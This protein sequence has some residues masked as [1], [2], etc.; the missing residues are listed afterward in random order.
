MKQ[1]KTLSVIALH[2]IAL[3]DEEVE[4]NATAVIEHV[5]CPEILWL[6]P[7]AQ[8]R[9]VTI[10]AGSPALAWY[11]VLTYDRTRMDEDGIEEATSMICRAVRQARDRNRFDRVVLMGFSQGGALALNAGLR[12]QDEVDGIVA[13]GTALPFPDR[14][15]SPRTALPVFLGHGLLDRKIPYAFGRETERL[16]K[17]KGYETE[18]HSYLC[19]HTVTRRLLRDI[20]VWL[21][22]NFLETV[23]ARKSATFGAA[24]RMPHQA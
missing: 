9:D 2:G 3:S 21:R 17:A 11:D 12:L 4:R 8:R 6:F 18:W 20:S 7:K 13:L 22:R 19:G 1:D 24:Y 23:P 5:A 10:L 14:V 16:L 15:T